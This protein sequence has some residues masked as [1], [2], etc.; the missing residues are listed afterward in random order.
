MKADVLYSGLDEIRKMI[1]EHTG[2]DG[3]VD[4]DGLRIQVAIDFTK[5]ELQNSISRS[6]AEASEESEE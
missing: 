5:T 2:Q 4:F 3:E 6:R 1:A